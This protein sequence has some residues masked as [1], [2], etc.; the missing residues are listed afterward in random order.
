MWHV[1]IGTGQPLRQSLR[2]HF[3]VKTN[4]MMPS[5]VVDEGIQVAVVIEGHRRMLPRQRSATFPPSRRPGAA[6]PAAGPHRRPTRRLTA[7]VTAS[8]DGLFLYTIADPHRGEV[9]GGIDWVGVGA[10]DPEKFPSPELLD[11]QP[12]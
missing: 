6:R 1:V 4:E 10:R 3:D 11:I 12:A 2:G 9:L 7:A 8:G 5:A